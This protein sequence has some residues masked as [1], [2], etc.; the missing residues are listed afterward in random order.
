MENNR[1]ESIKS[2]IKNKIKE[3][4]MVE[5]VCTQVQLAEVCGVTKAS[6]S[7]WI[8]GEA[9]PDAARIPLIAEGLKISV[10]ELLG[11]DSNAAE[12]E[13]AIIFYEAYLK[14]PKYQDAIAKLLE[15]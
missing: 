15:L 8:I 2:H 12:L 7:T 5:K 9:C 1:Y 4:I 10:A 13:K 6:V 11:L 3:K 14:N